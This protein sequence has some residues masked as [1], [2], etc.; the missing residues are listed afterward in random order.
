LL[1]EFRE[2]LGK[3]DVGATATFLHRV[4]GFGKDLEDASKILDTMLDRGSRYKQLEGS[5]GVG[6]LFILPTNIGETK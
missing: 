5:L 1:V 3:P 4:G 2:W 6:V